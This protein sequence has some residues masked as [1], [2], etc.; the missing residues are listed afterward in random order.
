MFSLGH[1]GDVAPLHR[2][3]VGQ[4]QHRDGGA[5]GPAWDQLNSKWCDILSLVNVVVQAGGQ[6][7][8]AV[9][10]DVEV[11]HH[12]SVEGEREEWGDSLCSNHCV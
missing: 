12:V 1:H 8:E 10:G 9:G 5:V 3:P 6:G 4:A 7:Q 2:Q 11:V